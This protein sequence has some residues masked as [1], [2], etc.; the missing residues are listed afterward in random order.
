MVVQASFME[1]A[2]QV[3]NAVTGASL[4]LGA[5]AMLAGL[6]AWQTQKGRA[7]MTET[8]LDFKV[9]TEQNVSERQQYRRCC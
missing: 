6:V 8:W 2:G 9:N 1:S 3:W 5:V 4:I 7:W